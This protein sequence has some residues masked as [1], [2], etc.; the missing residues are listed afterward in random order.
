MQVQLID[1]ENY[2]EM[3]A[4]RM[5]LEWFGARVI[6]DSVATSKQLI[7]AL[8]HPIIKPDIAVLMCHGVDDGLYLGELAPD[9]AKTQP[10]N[11]SINATQFREF[12]A[13]DGY[14][15]INNGCSLGTEDYA[16]A[17]LDCG[18]TTYIGAVDDESGNASLMYLITL[19]YHLFEHKRSL[20]IA[21]HHASAIDK[22]THMFKLYE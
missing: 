20:S 3:M 14:P 19:F 16:Q 1:V 17:F 6:V 9:I 4:F 8:N 21:H 5:A 18:T 15:I 10:Y 2:P 12:L 13:I 22:D 11:G 7:R